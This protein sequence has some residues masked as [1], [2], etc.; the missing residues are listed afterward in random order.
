MTT[1]R[2]VE[3]DAQ[4]DV[5]FWIRE[6]G[7]Q[8]PFSWLVCEERIYPVCAPHYL[9]GRAPERPDDLIGL[10]LLHY[11]D[12]HR[13]RMT[14]DEWFR[15]LGVATRPIVAVDTFHDHQLVL[16]AALSGTGI[17][18]GWSFSTQ[19]LRQAGLLVRPI[20][21]EVVTGKAY[22][23]VASPRASTSAEIGTLVDWLRAEAA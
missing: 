4:I 10:N 17:A 15:A 3:P 22:F 1:D 2:D 14:W 9:A 6:M 12:D 16:Q 18:L 13:D 11:L 8:R 19:L 5:T 20:A 21:A 7:F 23:L